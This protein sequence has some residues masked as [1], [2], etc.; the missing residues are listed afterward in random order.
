MKPWIRVAGL[1]FVAIALGW[2]LSSRM[3][4]GD[5][6]DSA[7]VSGEGGSQVH[8]EIAGTIVRVAPDDG[9]MTVDH[10]AI[11]GFMPAMVMDLQLAEPGELAAF[12]PGDAIVFDLVSIGSTLQAVRLRPADGSA[13]S[14]HDRE[15]ENPLGRG[16]LVPDLELYDG[17]GNR[18]RLAEM[19]P[20]HK[21][22]T[23]FY[24][25]CPLQD[26]CPTQSQRLAQLQQHAPRSPEGVHL[27]SL[28]LDSDN[29]SV[30]ALAEYGDRF[31]ADPRRW[32][33]AGGEDAEAI[34]EFADRAGARIMSDDESPWIDHALI[35]LR[36]DGDRIVDLVYGLE[37]IEGLVRGM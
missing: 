2:F 37:A 26:F 29:D 34:R 10:E 4:G 16:D 3:T 24:I 9:V 35:A 19:E 17:A 27:V 25:R 14:A 12:S 36:I 5:P 22:V 20:R 13:T 7:G 6:P 32:T 33:L 1:L 11:D 18:F 30:E 21:V 8:R 23:F 28:S 15:P 31:G